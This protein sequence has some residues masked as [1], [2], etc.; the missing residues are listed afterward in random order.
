MCKKES[1]TK[2]KEKYQMYILVNMKDFASG[3][4][5]FQFSLVCV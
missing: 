1:K 4:T 3:I 2:A 5:L